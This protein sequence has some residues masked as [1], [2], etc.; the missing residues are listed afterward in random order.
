MNKLFAFILLGVLILAAGLAKAAPVSD[1]LGTVTQF[2]KKVQLAYKNASYLSCNLL[3]RYANSNHLTK[4]IDTLAG[5]MAIDKNRMRLVID[6]VVTLN[7]D[8]YTVQVLKEDKLIYLSTP[9]SAIGADPIQMLDTILTH[10]NGVQSDVERNKG[11]V[12]LNISFPPGQLY[13]KVS[14]TINES[15]GFF[16]KVAYELFTESLLSEDQISQTGK[17]APY[18]PEGR[19]EVLFS[20]Y[21]Q[22]KFNDSLFNEAIYFT[23]VGKGNYEPTEQYKDYQIFLAS[24]SL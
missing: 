16:E 22:G 5:D 12:T 7:T 14:M 8:H 15:T 10:M 11:T 13:K 6:D 2:M 4:Y 21:R 20:N 9:R 19:V 23:R 24:P 3:Y 18:Q 1:S 17:P